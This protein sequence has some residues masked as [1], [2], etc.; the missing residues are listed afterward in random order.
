MTD[1]VAGLPLDFPLFSKLKL[2]EIPRA[3]AAADPRKLGFACLEDASAQPSAQRPA[4]LRSANLP[5]AP[6]TC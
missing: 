5:V 4:Q 3:F 2:R 6:L 1:G